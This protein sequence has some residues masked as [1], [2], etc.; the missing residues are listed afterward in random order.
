MLSPTTRTQWQLPAGE[1]FESP[2]CVCAYSASGL[3]GISKELHSLYRSRLIPPQWRDYVCPVLINTWEAMYF[4]TTHERVMKLARQAK[5]I[6]VDML[7][8]DDGWFGCRDD[9]TSR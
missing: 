9:D 3:G 4:D 6:G 2:E 1:S 7:V 5:A 8:L